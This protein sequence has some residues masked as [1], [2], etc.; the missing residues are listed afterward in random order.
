GPAPR[1][2]AEPKPASRVSEALRDIVEREL[3][4]R[5]SRTRF[6]DHEELAFR[7]ALVREAAY[8]SLTDAD[9]M[10]GHR[11]A[12][13]WLEAAGEPSA[14]VLAEHFERGG[15]HLRAAEQY[16][17]AARDALEGNDFAAVVDLV[18]RAIACGAS[19][20]ALGQLRVRQAEAQRWRGEFA[21]AER[22]GLEAI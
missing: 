8:A 2:P 9:R 19:G 16:G 10:L 11:L 15:E 1:A 22:R 14:R 18:D 5:R 21:E 7:N 12:G 13:A 3:V 6:S 4:V 20:E 17:H